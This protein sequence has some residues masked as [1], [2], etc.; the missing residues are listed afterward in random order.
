MADDLM[1]YRMRVAH[2]NTDIHARPLE[3]RQ[4]VHGNQRVDVF[5]PSVLDVITEDDAD[6]HDL[7]DSES[8]TLRLVTSSSTTKEEYHH[9]S[10]HTVLHDGGSSYECNFVRPHY[11]YP[12]HRS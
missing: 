9:T 1:E 10:E 4:L 8:N 7:D 2:A 3:G 5:H 6:E 12:V 11:V